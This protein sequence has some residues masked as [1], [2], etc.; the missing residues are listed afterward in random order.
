MNVFLT[1]ATG[2]IGSAVADAIVRAGHT[3]TGLIRP[4]RH[5]RNLSERGI[6][7]FEGR[8]QEPDTLAAEAGRADA[9]IHTA[10]DPDPN[11][12]LADEA[13]VAAALDALAG[14]SKP[15]LYTSGL[16]VMGNTKKDADEDS[17]LDPPPIVAWRAAVERRVMEAAARGVR[18]VVIRPATVYGRGGGLVTNF[19]KSA[20]ETG[21]AL[22]PGDGANHWTFVHIDDLAAL[23]VL[24]LGAEPGSLF[25]AASGPALRLSE[26]ARAASEAAGAGGRTATWEL[27]EALAVLGPSVQG[28]VLD[29]RVSGRKAER[30]LGWKPQGAPVLDEIRCTYAAAG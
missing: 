6:R 2:Y 14:S 3:V 21:A 22:I 8:L 12:P 17:P 13:F 30:V 27:D 25:I 4:G 24:A 20:R 16:W 23:Y 29:Q 1:G 19:S 7:P 28:L 15:F 11:G 10:R 5:P 18:S 26:V 9:V